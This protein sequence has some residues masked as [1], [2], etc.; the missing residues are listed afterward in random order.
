M[1]TKILIKY[2]IKI[3]LYFLHPCANTQGG[4]DLRKLTIISKGTDQPVKVI[5]RLLSLIKVCGRI[6]FNL[7]VIN[8]IKNGCRKHTPINQLQLKF[9]RSIKLPYV[10]DVLWLRRWMYVFLL[11]YHTWSTKVST[12]LCTC[13]DWTKPSPTELLVVYFMTNTK[14]FYNPLSTKQVSY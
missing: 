2:S 6:I 1:L 14:K 12:N 13:A 8:G 7:W 4:T 11:F 9:D 3:I 10:G 5:G